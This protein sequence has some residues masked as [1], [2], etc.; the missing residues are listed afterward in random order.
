MRRDILCL[1]FVNFWLRVCEGQ[2]SNDAE[3]R[4]IS[5]S[6]HRMLLRPV[7]SEMNKKSLRSLEDAIVST[8]ILHQLKEDNHDF[9]GNEV[10][11]QEIAHIKASA[12]ENETSALTRVQFF[13]IGSTL[14]NHTEDQLQKQLGDLLESTFTSVASVQHF[15]FL[16]SSDAILGEVSNVSVW[17]LISNSSDTLDRNEP[18][19]HP[20]QPFSLLDILLMCFSGLILLG[21]LYMVVQHHTDRRYIENER[22][23]L[24]NRRQNDHSESPRHERSSIN[25]ISDSAG[26]TNKD[27]SSMGNSDSIVD[28]EY[29][30]KQGAA[31]L[32]LSA[33]TTART[34][35][36]V[37]ASEPI[38]DSL[39]VT[40]TTPQLGISP[41]RQFLPEK[42]K[43]KRSHPRR[44]LSRVRW[45][46]AKS[47]AAFRAEDPEENSA[48]D[49]TFEDTTD[50]SVDLFNVDMCSLSEESK[51]TAASA[52]SEWMK[53]IRV[54][55]T[56]VDQGEPRSPS[57]TRD[58]DE[59]KRDAIR[60]ETVKS[61]SP[62]VSS[63]S[64][65]IPSSALSLD[66]STDASSGFSTGNSSSHDSS[67]MESK[68]SEASCDQIT[69]EQF[70]ACPRVATNLAEKMEV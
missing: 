19:T 25:T 43:Q 47:A 13:V 23:T 18:N 10:A 36:A 59:G 61:I 24:F 38:V 60:I 9:F 67:L 6:P 54:A 2:E 44:N 1:I 17:P 49:W 12:T 64:G 21:I 48:E 33:R 27:L 65:S 15:L 34:A 70:M 42:Y 14:L 68:A 53:T 32:S 50:H 63:S 5:S 31:G 52:V 7:R 56:H 22:Q 51:P 11:I 37:S 29:N 45:N 62:S 30:F 16:I 55:S 40:S 41:N 20:I 28:L 35:G 66:L 57:M 58:D 3:E 4:F 69:L 39:S 26:T 8:L 46:M